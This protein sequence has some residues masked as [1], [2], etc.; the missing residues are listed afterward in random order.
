[1]SYDENAEL[2]H[3]IRQHHSSLYTPFEHRVEQ[4]AHARAKFANRLGERGKQLMARYGQMGDA[5][6]DEALAEGLQAFRMRVARR[7][8]AQHPDL[9]INRCRR[10]NCILRTPKAM[11]CFWCGYD[12]HVA[13]G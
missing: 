13:N 4:A 6:F 10:C 12:W 9:Q 3:Y 5:K 2:R 11:Q 7:I 1:M 8:L